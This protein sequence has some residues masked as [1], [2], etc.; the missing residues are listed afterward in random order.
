MSVENSSEVF[1]RLASLDRDDVR[2]WYEYVGGIA[3]NFYYNKAGPVV[4]S[5]CVEV[6]DLTHAG[7]IGYLEAVRSW[8]GALCAYFPPYAVVRIVGA[9]RDEI[10]RAVWGSRARGYAR[11]NGNKIPHYTMVRMDEMPEQRFCIDWDKECGTV[12]RFLNRLQPKRLRIVMK[13]RFMGGLSLSEI[14]ASLDLTESRICQLID[15]GVERVLE[16]AGQPDRTLRP[17]FHSCKSGSV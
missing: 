7:M 13:M 15:Y 10:R 3:A 14:G 4:R 1:G 17:R 9:V 12:E 16:M 2:G 5:S 6:T 11:R 8:D